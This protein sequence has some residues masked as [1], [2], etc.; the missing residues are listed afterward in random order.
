MKPQSRNYLS[1]WADA[2]FWWGS[3]SRA[4]A[5]TCRQSRIE[6]LPRYIITRLQSTSYIFANASAIII[7]HARANITTW[8][9]TITPW[10]QHSGRGA[11]SLAFE[12]HASIAHGTNLMHAAMHTLDIPFTSYVKFIFLLGAAS[13]YDLYITCQYAQ[14]VLTQHDHLGYSIAPIRS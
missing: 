8:A 11:W 2:I 10:L 12:Q 3:V 14:D 5:P 7:Q 13:W 4:V 9:A 6:N 1:T